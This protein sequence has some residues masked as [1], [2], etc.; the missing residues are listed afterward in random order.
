MVKSVSVSSASKWRRRSRKPPAELRV[1]E[2][3]RLCNPAKRSPKI[4]SFPYYVQYGWIGTDD[5]DDNDSGRLT[6]TIVDSAVC[7]PPQQ[8]QV[9]SPKYIRTVT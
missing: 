6:V 4:R 3:D 1:R 2:M 9:L 5:D 7:L 8:Q